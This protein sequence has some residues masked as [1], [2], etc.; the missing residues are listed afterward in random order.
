MFVLYWINK[1]VYMVCICIDEFDIVMYRIKKMLWFKG[2]F[3]NKFM[4]NVKIYKLKLL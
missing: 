1:L 3:F 2:I 4:V